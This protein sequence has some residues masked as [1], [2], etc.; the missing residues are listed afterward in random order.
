MRTF[1]WGVVVIV[2]LLAAGHFPVRTAS[3]VRELPLSQRG[4]GPEWE[5]WQ[6]PKPKRVVHKRSIAATLRCIRH[7]ESRGRY[8]AVSATGRYRG[9]AQWSQR[10][11]DYTI[12]R[13]W[14]ERV[15]LLGADPAQV[16]PADQDEMTVRLLRAEG[17][18]HWPTPARRCA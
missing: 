9:A 14:P 7:F 10:T 8:N 6:A 15:D 2:V 4:S 3:V 1:A 12:R 17:I 5:A 16:A 11:W 18:R 13:Y